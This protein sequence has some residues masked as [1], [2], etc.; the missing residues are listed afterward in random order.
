MKGYVYLI[1][2]K[3]SGKKYVGKTITSIKQRWKEHIK[4]YKKYNYPLYKAMRKYGIENFTISE[5][6]YV[7]NCE[8]REKYWIEYYNSYKEG[9]NATLGGEG[10]NLYSYS[11]IIELYKEGYCSSEIC[12]ILGCNKAVIHRAL[13]TS[14]LVIKLGA[15]IT[16]ER[17]SIHS[18]ITH[19]KYLA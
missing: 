9:Y 10:S 2:N 13:L 1:E 8:E 5:I 6:E 7:E 16:K 19:E 14:N 12:K 18:G 17:Y 15:E 11:K 4:S 3:I